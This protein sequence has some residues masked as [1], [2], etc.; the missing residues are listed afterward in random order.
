M[1]KHDP[2]TIGTDPTKDILTFKIYDDLLGLLLLLFL[3]LLELGNGLTG[4]AELHLQIYKSQVTYAD[5]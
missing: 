1:L 5:N 4:K 3:P 2:N